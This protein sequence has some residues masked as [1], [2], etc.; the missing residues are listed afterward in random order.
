MAQFIYPSPAPKG[1]PSPYKGEGE[2][3][4]KR[5][6]SDTLVIATHNAGKLKEFAHLFGDKIPNIISAGD[7]NLPE[8]DET[9]AS[10]TDNAILKAQAAASASGHP[11]L[12]D[13]SGLAVTALNGAPGIYSARWAGDDKNFQAAMQRVQNELG[14]VADRSAAFICVL[15]LAWPDGHVEIAEGRVDGEIVWPPRGKQ[16]FGYDPIFTPQNSNKTFAEI[17]FVEKQQFS[18]RR[19]AFD[20]LL[21]KCFD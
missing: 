1:A 7:L 19:R 3:T 14:D 5:F 11:A 8:P 15:A 9:G 17:D 16:G 21:K 6:T 18:H 20:A 10:F 13:D 2:T 12:A 4:I